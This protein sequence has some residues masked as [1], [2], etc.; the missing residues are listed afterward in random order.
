[1]KFKLL[2]RSIF[3]KNVFTLMASIAIC[4]LISI[5]VSFILTRIYTPEEFG[6][7]SIYMGVSCILLVVATARY[8]L[9]IMLPEKDSDAVHIAVFTSILSFVVSLLIL[10]FVFVFNN[11]I[12]RML[13]SRNVSKWLYSIPFLLIAMSLFEIFSCWMNRK[14]NYRKMAESTITLAAVSESTKCGIGILKMSGNGLITGQIIGQCV[15]SLMLG[16]HFLKDVYADLKYIKFKK[17]LSHASAYKKFP[18]FNM[19]YSVIGVF[20]GEFLVFILAGFNYL[21]LSGFVGFTK[22]LIF[23]PSIF[24][25]A[26]LG[27]VFFQEASVNIHEPH[28]EKLTVDMLL[29]LAGLVTPIFVFCVFWAPEIFKYLFGQKWMV[30]GQYASVLAFPAFCLLFTSWPERIYEVKQKQHISF[31]IQI[32]F[33]AFNICIVWFLLSKGIKPLICVGIYSL[34]SCL[35]HI[36]YLAS[37]FKIARFRL[38]SFYSFIKKI[39]LIGTIFAAAIFIL[40]ISIRPALY[41]FL[42][43]LTIVGIYYIFSLFKYIRKGS[44]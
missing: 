17:M 20:S 11:Q 7:F 32:V 26:S 15:A 30:A 25:S 14:K 33:D 5:G 29:K 44:D 16:W 18:I 43:G 23:G 22:R 8:E 19:P 28:F 40:S 12:C 41:Q 35:F 21:Q 6:L 3:A 37:I 2:P 10:L 9:A 42:I 39:I 27:R 24:L 13:G 4:R 1:M 36:T 38:Y 34:I 31:T